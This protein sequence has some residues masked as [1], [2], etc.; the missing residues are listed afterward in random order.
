[1][2]MMNSF[3]IFK[4]KMRSAHLAI[5]GRKQLFNHQLNRLKL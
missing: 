3:K 5:K 2:K 4:K 1:M